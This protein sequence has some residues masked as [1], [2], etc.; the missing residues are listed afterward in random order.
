MAFLVARTVLSRGRLRVVMLPAFVAVSLLASVLRF[1]RQHEEAE[2]QAVPARWL[3]A[4]DPRGSV[5]VRTEGYPPDS[6]KVSGLAWT[7]Q[8]VRF[9]SDNPL[10]VTPD[11]NAGYTLAVGG[12]GV[13]CTTPSPRRP[14]ICLTRRE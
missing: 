14:P 1:D 9:L 12:Q 5:E 4:H 3:A 6:L 2:R 13:I 8:Q 10:G 11:S 7:V